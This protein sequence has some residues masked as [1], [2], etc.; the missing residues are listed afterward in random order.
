MFVGFSLASLSNVSI[1]DSPA[2]R[3]SQKNPS[4][5]GDCGGDT[6]A[7][8]LLRF[9]VGLLSM[10]AERSKPM[11][12]LTISVTTM[13]PGPASIGSLDSFDRFVRIWGLFAKPGIAVFG[14]RS[15]ASI[16]L[17]GFPNC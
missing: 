13:A 9:V 15:G 7:A 5:P 1:S 2:A 12:K 3:S 14:F 11:S 6:L 17:A 4:D 8:S 16:E 10:L